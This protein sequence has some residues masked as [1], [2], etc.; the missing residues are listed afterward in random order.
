[1]IQGKC[2]LVWKIRNWQGGEVAKQ[3]AHAKVLGLTNVC[4]KIVDDTTERW[5]SASYYPNTQNADYLP[6]LVPA[7][8]AA[9]IAVSAWGYTYG[10]Y[11]TEPYTSIGAAEGAKTAQVMRKY[12]I[13]DFLVDAET[14]YERTGL[15]MKAEAVAYML[16]LKNGFPSA[17]LYLCA[18]RFPVYHTAF[19]WN[20]FLAKCVG[21]APQVY[22][23]Q[24]MAVDAGALQLVE[25]NKELQALKVLPFVGIAP[26]YEHSSPTGLKWRA[27][28]AQLLAFF[29]KA[30][31]LGMPGVGVWALDLASTEQ[32]AALAEFA[33]LVA[34][35]PEPPQPPQPPQAA[36]VN[37]YLLA[38]DV[39]ARHPTAGYTGVRP[40]AT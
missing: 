8:R 19:P 40:P 23:L 37:E 34:Q 35:P 3:V 22:F 20:E 29:Q 25:S 32:M 26:T 2:A 24:A 39:W 30:K 6:A 7:L 33:W 1:M 10:K 4:L 16:A 18:F 28:K 14:E 31:D 15:N 27:S 17:N 9:G 5:E 38:L 13:V 21:H 12:G 11:K 36:T